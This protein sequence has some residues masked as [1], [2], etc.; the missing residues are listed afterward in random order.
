MSYMSSL[1]IRIPDNM[2]RELEKLSQANQV[3]VSDLVR[4]SLRQ[5]VAVQQYRNLRSRVLAKAQKKNFIVD[6][7]VFKAVS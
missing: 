1:T 3:P 4:D 6:E 2:R 5:Y 7:D